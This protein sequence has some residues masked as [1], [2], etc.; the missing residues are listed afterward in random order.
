MSDDDEVM[1]VSDARRLGTRGAVARGKMTSFMTCSANCAS[2]NLARGQKVVDHQGRERATRRMS[3]LRSV[4][5]LAPGDGPF[6]HLLEVR[7]A[8]IDESF[9]NDPAELGVPG[10]R[11]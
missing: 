2:G 11:P 6:E 8:G 5:N 7:L 10:Q 9:A 1:A 4:G 3:R